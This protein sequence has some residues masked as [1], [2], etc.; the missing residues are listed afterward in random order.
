VLVGRKRALRRCLAELLEV[1]PGRRVLDVGCGTGTLALHFAKA[2]RPSGWVIGLDA[3]AEM[4]AAAAARSRRQG[5]QA[6]FAVAAAQRLPFPDSCFDAVLTSLM[7]HH[8]PAP[9]RPGAVAELLRVL[10]PGGRLVLADFKPPAGRASRAVARHL[11]GPSM[12]GSDVADITDLVRD[13]GALEVAQMPTPVGWLS[14][15]VARAPQPCDQ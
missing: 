3:A 6:E 2:V 10:G 13:A 9:D 14:A 11:L 5:A 15:V 1:R 12:A 4:I 8:L 7:L